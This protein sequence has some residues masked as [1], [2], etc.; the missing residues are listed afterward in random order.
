MNLVR[1]TMSGL[2]PACLLAF[3]LL[4]AVRPERAGASP[5]RFA[6]TGTVEQSTVSGI[7]AGDPF[8]GTLSY[9][10]D[11]PRQDPRDPN[12][13]AYAAPEPFDLIRLR[14][15]VGSQTFEIADPGFA[16]IVVAH[17]TEI[18]GPSTYD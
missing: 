3:V 11:L 13:G 6:F 5:I 8:T 1:K 15:E 2:R 4:A 18:W 9:D 17:N 14:V 7:N 16:G 12:V 10:T